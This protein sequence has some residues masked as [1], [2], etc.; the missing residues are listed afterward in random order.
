METVSDRFVR[1]IIRLAYLSPGVLERLVIWR[2][3][4]SVTVNGLA[5]AASLLGAKQVERVFD[6]DLS[7]G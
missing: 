3:A 4:P 1:R 6:E 7:R 5:K 2:V